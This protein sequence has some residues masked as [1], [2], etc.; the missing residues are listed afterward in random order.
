MGKIIIH[1]DDRSGLTDADAL[2]YVKTIIE[3]GRISDNN[4]A[5]CYLSAFGSG[6]KVA[7]TKNAKSDTFV[8]YG[9]VASS[10]P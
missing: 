8:V 1:N 5:Y 10:K 9:T 2:M 3:G 7:A 4:T 6:V